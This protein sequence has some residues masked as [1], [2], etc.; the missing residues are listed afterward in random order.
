MA[1]FTFYDEGILNILK[2]LIDLDG[3]TFKAVLTNSAPDAAAHDELADV[4]QIANGGG[5]TTGGETLTSVGLAETSGGS[6]VWVW[7]AAD[8]SWTATSGGM[9]EFRYVVIY[10]DTSSGDKLVGY[11]DYGSGLTI[12]EGNAFTVDVQSGGIFQASEA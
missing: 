6:G 3:D 10:S 11:L 12:E 1:T 9:A 8:F 4:T 5:Y 7:S 2:A